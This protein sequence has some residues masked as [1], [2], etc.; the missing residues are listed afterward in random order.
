M[1]NIIVKNNTIWLPE[2]L[3]MERLKIS[4]NYIRRARCNFKK[5]LRKSQT[6]MQFFP[7]NG[8]S[9]RYGKINS[10]FYYDYDRIP[11]R[12]PNHYRSQLPTRAA[13]VNMYNEQKRQNKQNTNDVI[14]K[15][16]WS[17]ATAVTNN[18]D[19]N[20]YCYHAPVNFAPNKANQLAQARQLCNTIRAWT[21]CRKYKKHG[22]KKKEDF[23]K[24]AAELTNEK[25]LEGLK[26]DTPKSLR[27]RLYYQWPED[28]ETQLKSLIS[29][30]YGN[31]NRSLIGKQKVVDIE[32]GEIMQFDIHEAVIYNAWMNPGAAN[33]LHKTQVYN[34][35]LVECQDL[36]IDPV[37][38]R[39]VQHHLNKF[40]NRALMS[41][42]RDG[43]DH[44]TNKYK[45]YIPQF[46]PNYSSSLWVADFSGTK[47][48]YRYKK[49]VWRAGKKVSQITSGSW[50][51]LRIVDAATDYI[52]GWGLIENGEDWKHLLPALNMALEQNDN[53]AACELVTDN[54]PAF[55]S[56]EGKTRLAMLFNKHRCIAVG[57]KQANKAEM[58]V[59]LLSDKARKFANW[60]MLG[61]YSRH[62]DNVANPDYMDLKQLPW[63]EEAAAQ[64]E[65]LVKEW[66]NTP[67]PNG[68]IPAEEWAKKERRNPQCKPI[69]NNVHRFVFGN[70]TTYTLDRCRGVFEVSKGSGEDRLYYKFQF[71][72]WLADA[73]TID[74]ALYGEP[75]MKVKVVWDEKGADIYTPDQKY[76]LT[77][78]PAGFSH[79]TEYEATPESIK[80]FEQ[81]QQN[82]KRFEKAAKDYRENVIETVEA[83]QPVD[84]DYTQRAALN[85]GKAKEDHNKIMESKTNP[86]HNDSYDESETDFDVRD[87]Y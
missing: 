72:D 23:F 5:T 33:K 41:Y 74:K 69:N 49:T 78:K 73:E 40:H 63:R 84:L 66:N 39:T 20:Y 17:T 36:D 25:Q 50:Y 57:N 53:H 51:M 12:N 82:K 18:E 71:G 35:Y 24:I 28:R 52:V 68:T 62:P 45:P 46:K 2:P 42:E 55:T 4:Y 32:T 7:D 10:I 16:L 65:Q 13:L 60:A 58:Y 75:S 59:R 56:N 30:K 47:L 83:L 54:G 64:V 15:A 9:W 6:N 26:I 21:E 76:I 1:N 37:A 34:N 43:N 61:F 19:I 81:H 77:A 87:S 48:M 31:N 70:H 79:P 14:K 22:I 29:K 27:K 44:F 86:L 11:D 80:A 8:N 85:R 67:R 3:I 38:E